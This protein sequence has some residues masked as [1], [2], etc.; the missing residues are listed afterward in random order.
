M[1]A[2]KLQH[3]VANLKAYLKHLYTKNKY[4]KIW[5]IIP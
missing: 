2:A 1:T 5:S 4:T 3:Y